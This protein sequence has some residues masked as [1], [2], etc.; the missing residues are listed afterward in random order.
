MSNLKIHL[1]NHPLLF[2]HAL[3]KILLLNIQLINN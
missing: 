1:K 3:F 2:N